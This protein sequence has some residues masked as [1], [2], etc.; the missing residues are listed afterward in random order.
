LHARTKIW[1]RRPDIPAAV[2]K[3]LIARHL[4]KEAHNIATGSTRTHLEVC[5]SVLARLAVQALQ[6]D[7]FG[8]PHHRLAT[9]IK[10]EVQFLTS[11]LLGHGGRDLQPMSAPCLAKRV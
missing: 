10:H 11:P 1:C 9:A 6:R 8:R 5:T 2:T 3:Q 4:Q 7:T